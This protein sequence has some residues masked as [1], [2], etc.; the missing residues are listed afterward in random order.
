MGA[1]F[2]V[3]V[4]FMSFLLVLRLGKMGSEKAWFWQSAKRA[5]RGIISQSQIG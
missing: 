3:T 2:V 5:A 4:S 1:C